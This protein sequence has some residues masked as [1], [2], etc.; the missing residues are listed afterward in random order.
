MG[1]SLIWSPVYK[2]IEKRIASD[3]DIILMLVPF[4]KLAALQRLRQIH[5]RFD[6]LKIICRWRP[7]DLLFGASDVEIYP[8][9]RDAGCGL[10]INKDIHL[11]LYI[12]ASNVAF[13]TSGNLT[14]RG[15]GYSESA[16]IETGSMV[17]LTPDDWIQ[18]YQLIGTSRQVDDALY[19]RYK[20]FIEEH[21]KQKATED[22]ADFTSPGKAYTISSLPA[23]INP[24][25][26]AAFCFNRGSRTYSPEEVRRAAHDLANFGISAN[27][28]ESDFDRRLGEAFRTTLFVSDF[29]G[30]LQSER[31]L[32][33]GAVNEWIHQKCEDVPLPYRWEIKENTCIFY[34]WLA[35]F[36]PEVT[37]DRP[38][39]SQVIYWNKGKPSR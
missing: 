13:N 21:P 28:E 27:L 11:K 12:F 8:F 30:Y 7:D 29:I 15:L 16:N 24:M 37:W 5:G 17:V 35:H 2:A 26:L 4:V 34:N 14:M 1:S 20:T 3:D 18:I 33:F 25:W 10:Y 32:R 36:I 9:L 6:Q 39:H 23:T 31:S 19:H 22:F 38:N